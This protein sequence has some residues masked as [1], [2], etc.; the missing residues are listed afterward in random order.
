LNRASQGQQLA[1]C[2]RAERDALRHCPRLQR[3]VIDAIVADRTVFIER[4]KPDVEAPRPVRDIMDAGCERADAV[5]AAT[6]HAVKDA[7]GLGNI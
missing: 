6:T 2:A 5:A 3:P 4:A 7:S 1:S